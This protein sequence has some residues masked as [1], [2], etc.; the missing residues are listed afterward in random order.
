MD[1]GKKGLMT[2]F[3]PRFAGGMV[4]LSRPE[5][6]VETKPYK[7]L[8]REW[9]QIKCFCL[10]HLKTFA[11]TSVLFITCVTTFPCTWTCRLFQCCWWAGR[12]AGWVGQPP[13]SWDLGAV[14]GTPSSAACHTENLGVKEHKGQTLDLP[15]KR[16]GFFV[17]RLYFGMGVLLLTPW[18]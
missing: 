1:I 3:S 2:L 14:W 5:D 8:H 15:V 13:V 9:K 12:S 4:R 11:V 6:L 16:F 17:S 10:A 7:Q 18:G